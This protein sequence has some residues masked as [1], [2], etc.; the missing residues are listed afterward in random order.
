MLCSDQSYQFEG[1]F[2]KGRPTNEKQT[3]FTSTSIVLRWN[4]AL[5]VALRAVPQTI[6]PVLIRDR[7]VLPGEI[8]P[9]DF[10]LVRLGTV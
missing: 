1:K 3:C 6:Y 2:V 7:M 10:N 9:S 5:T 8:F 4:P